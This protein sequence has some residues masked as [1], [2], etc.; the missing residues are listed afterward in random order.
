MDLDIGG[1]EYYCLHG[2]GL[3]RASWLIAGSRRTFESRTTTTLRRDC[4]GRLGLRYK[5]NESLAGEYCIEDEG[6]GEEIRKGRVRDGCF[7]I[8]SLVSLKFGVVTNGRR[9]AK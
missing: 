2:L 6:R 8:V 9:V 5:L 4:D 7:D 3:D 1:V